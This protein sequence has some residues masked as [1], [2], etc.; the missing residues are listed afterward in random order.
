MPHGRDH[1]PI[2]E[3]IG[4]VSHVL[5]V[6]ALLWSLGWLSGCTKKSTTPK[7]DTPHQP[8][9]AG[10]GSHADGDADAVTPDTPTTVRADDG[11]A[12][13]EATVYFA[14]DS[15]TLDEPS[16]DALARFADWLIAH[17][18]ARLSIAGHTDERGTDEY[19]VALGQRRAQA[20]ADYLTR[21]GVDAA[22]LA[23][24][25]YGEA[26]PAVAGET[27]EAWA[28]NRRGELAPTP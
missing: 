24:I 15:Y 27:E 12:P 28:K 1:D 13:R 9:G 22:R 19:N 25:S 10:S 18:E 3:V 17:P 6:G 20:I 5:L 23:T 21:Y 26:R 14:F 2:P 7:L 11:A 8:T 16:R 4:V